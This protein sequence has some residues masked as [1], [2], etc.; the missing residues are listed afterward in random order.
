MSRQVPFVYD[1]RDY[2]QNLGTGSTTIADYGCYLTSFSQCL[3]Y[4]GK[5]VNPVQLNTL[6]I[7]K[8]LFVNLNEMVDDNLTKVYPDVIYQESLHYEAIPADLEKIKTLLSDPTLYIILEIDE[9]GTHRH[10]V[11]CLG[12]NGVVT[13]ANPWTGEI[14]D[15]AKLYGDP[16]KNILKV[17]V[18][19]GTPHL[20]SDTIDQQP[21]IDQ[22]RTDRDKNYNLY[23]EEQKKNADLT[24]ENTS[25]QTN[26]AQ[27]QQRNAS[28]AD[29]ISQMEKADSTA[30]DKGVALQVLVTD[31]QDYLHAI[32]DSVKVQFDGSKL[33]DVVEAI[34][35]AI[36]ALQKPLPPETPPI[37]TPTET[38]NNVN[39]L[40]SLFN[41]IKNFV[42]VSKD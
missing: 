42:W 30:V 6:F 12:V 16:V 5:Y 29:Q 7:Q 11:T 20:T 8:N 9:G 26:I 15:F 38:V 34:L 27:V 22:L 37:D 1:Q 14:E 32:A 3:L 33:K 13:I 25:L 24:T 19:K 36:N 31:L 2:L 18:Y 41:A 21:L 35:G 10:F 4:Y 39:I 40:M 28:L 23:T 17:V